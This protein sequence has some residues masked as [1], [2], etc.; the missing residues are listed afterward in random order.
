VSWGGGQHRGQLD[1]EYRWLRTWRTA[2]RL[3]EHIRYGDRTGIGQP[4]N[5]SAEPVTIRP[6][7]AG[8][9]IA[10]PLTRQEL[11]DLTTDLQVR[12]IPVQVDPIQALQIQRHMTITDIPRRHRPESP[13]HASRRPTL[14]SGTSWNPNPS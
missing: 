3:L 5:S 7:T 4:T 13:S 8:E 9:G 2:L 11:H 6:T 1:A 10:N 12:H 14:K